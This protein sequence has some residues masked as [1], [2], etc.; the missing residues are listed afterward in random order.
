MPT[1]TAVPTFE[2]FRKRM[3]PLTKAPYV[4]IQRR[5]TMSFNKSA[6]AALGSPEAV[7]LLYDRDEQIIGVRPVDR[8]VEHAY[9]IR[10]SGGGKADPGS[11]MVSGRAFVQ[12]YDIDTELSRRYP[13]SMD[14]DVL[15]IALK[16]GGTVVT[17][18][19]NGRRAPA[20]ADS[21]KSPE[22]P[23]SQGG[24]S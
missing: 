22:E 19:R 9:P 1:M 14:G 24:A 7:E 13:V 10:P 8:S 15:C 6:Y 2:T 12:Y 17:S 3:V 5:G 16:E 21:A 4:T 23:P 18:N 11:W 20:A